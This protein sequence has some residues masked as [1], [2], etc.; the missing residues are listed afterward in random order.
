MS[1]TQ[2]LNADSFKRSYTVYISEFT[3][4]MDLLIYCYYKI[5]EKE[6]FNS[7]KFEEFL[8]NV[9]V[10]YLRKNKD[11]FNISYLGFEI[12]AGDIYFDSIR[13]HYIDIKVCNVGLLNSMKS[14][15][16]IYFSVEC[17]RL[18]KSSNKIKRYVEQGIF[19]YIEGKYSRFMPIALMVGFIEMGDI[20]SIV[21]DIN[22]KLLA[23]KKIETII[24]LRRYFM[25]DNFEGSYISKHNR[26]RN[27]GEIELYHLL[28]DYSDIIQ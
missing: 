23:L 10:N 7:N 9:L 17:K 26:K 5:I 27:L 20:N 16:N 13:V 3:S 12:E 2:G 18:D 1:I 24:E 4:V 28:F 21:T 6:R 25:K 15:E 14:D 19:R 22:Q 11:R 8:R